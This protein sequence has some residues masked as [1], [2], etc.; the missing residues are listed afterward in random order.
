MRRRVGNF[1][2]IV[3]L[4]VMVQLLAPIGATM[5]AAA[6][7]G[8]PLGLT[9][10]CSSQSDHADGSG[11]SSGQPASHSTCCPLCVL[12]HAGSTALAPVEPPFAA[13][14][15]SWQRVVWLADRPVPRERGG[16]SHAQARAPP[17]QS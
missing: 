8:D 15:V 5:F 10:I 16:A 3:M 17:I 9:P 14:Q 6:V 13:L 2:P 12:A 4:A 1:L 7:Y 11:H